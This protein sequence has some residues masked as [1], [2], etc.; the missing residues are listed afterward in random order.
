LHGV[1]VGVTKFKLSHFNPAGGE[2]NGDQ[3]GKGRGI[4]GAGFSGGTGARARAT[5]RKLR[6]TLLLSSDVK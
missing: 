1:R 6:S 2:R 5:S 4:G 3:A